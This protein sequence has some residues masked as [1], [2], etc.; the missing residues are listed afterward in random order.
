MSLGNEPHEVLLSLPYDTVFMDA[1]VRLIFGPQIKKVLGCQGCSG[2]P[3]RRL[4]GSQH[5]LCLPTGGV[6]EFCWLP[7]VTLIVA[8]NTFI[9][10]HHCLLPPSCPPLSQQQDNDK[11][12]TNQCNC[13]AGV[14]ASRTNATA[15]SL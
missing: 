2:S 9:I 4:S 1:E 10:H 6:S 5:D 8:L 13:S 14:I 3:T 11:S 15:A 7:K 12:L